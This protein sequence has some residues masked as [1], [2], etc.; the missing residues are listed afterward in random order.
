ML[1]RSN[2]GDSA[3]WGVVRSR[4]TSSIVLKMME[5]AGL[6]AVCQSFNQH[7]LRGPAP[8]KITTFHRNSFAFIP[9]LL[10]DCG[11]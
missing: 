7:V 10:V 9:K 3:E 6:V 8:R 4:F 1:F 2:P 5:K 11:V